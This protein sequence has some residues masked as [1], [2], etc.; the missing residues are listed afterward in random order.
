MAITLLRDEKELGYGNYQANFKKT[1][2]QILARLNHPSGQL[3]LLNADRLNPAVT[4]LRPYLL[5]FAAIDFDDANKVQ[6]AIELS[7]CLI[8]YPNGDNI[9]T[10]I[11]SNP[12]AGGFIYV[13][14]RFSTSDLVSRNSGDRDVE[15]A[16][17]L[18]ITLDMRG[19]TYRWI[20]PFERM[21]VPPRSIAG[22]SAAAIATRG[23]LTGFVDTGRMLGAVNPLREF[24]GWIWQ[25][26]Q[27]ASASDSEL[28]CAKSAFYSVRLPIEA[29]REAL[30]QGKRPEWPPSDLDKIVLRVEVF[31]PG[32]ASAVFDSNAPGAVA[33]FSFE[34]L[35]PLLLPGETVTLMRTGADA[36]TAVKI[37]PL[38]SEEQPARWI[39]QLLRRLPVDGFDAQLMKTDRV[40]T[41]LGNYDVVFAGDVRGVNQSLAVAATRMSWYVGAMLLA[42]IGAWLL[43]EIGLIRRVTVLN[44]RARNV[45]KQ[46]HGGKG[47]VNHDLSDLRGKDELG[48]LAT[49]LHELLQRVN[50]DVQ[51][52][53]IRA[54]QEKDMWHAVG[55][56]IM[57]PLQSLMALHAKSDDPSKRYIERM[58][59]AVRVLYGS[60]SPSEAIASSEMDLRH[61][62]LNLFL[63][64][65]AENA[66]SLDIENVRF[67]FHENEVR[68]NADEYALEDAIA[69]VL[70]NA[71]RYRAPGSAIRIEL[72]ATDSSA[73]IEIHNDGPHIDAVLLDRIFEYGVSDAAESAAAGNRGQ[74]LYVAKTY[75]A[76]MGGTIAANNVSGGVSFVLTLPR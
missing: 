76:K 50:D 57:S 20:A 42:V 2:E 41:A 54:E 64:Q 24:R 9:C 74:G 36:R 1:Q 59:Q 14:G 37:R 21:D 29:F 27:C 4:P 70:T 12:Y 19:E 39:D 25:S 30:V 49:A 65:V 67:S 31:A 56:E 61:L 48:T 5:P 34:E 22:S 58:Q 51:R 11:G 63:T 40:S 3:A 23:R 66:S 32:D 68:V 43:I 46:M 13:A 17:R 44:Q 35:R 16:H 60:A 73:Q 10:A 18:R 52:E 26:S 72:V 53:H 47:L 45:S 75:M 55:H 28:S 71:H 33:P 8:R 6:Q 7:G 15:L 69:H 38:A 62:E